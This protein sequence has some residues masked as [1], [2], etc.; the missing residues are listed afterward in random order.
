MTIP[1]EKCPNTVGFPQL[2]LTGVCAQHQLPEE[3][4]AHKSMA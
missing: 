1:S 2:F 3:S 4:I